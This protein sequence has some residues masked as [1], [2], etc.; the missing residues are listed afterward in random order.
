MPSEE[1]TLFVLAGDA[2]N[3]LNTLAKIMLFFWYF[4]KSNFNSFYFASEIIV[5]NGIF[6]AIGETDLLRAQETL[7]GEVRIALNEMTTLIMALTAAIWKK[8]FGDHMDAEVCLEVADAPNS[9]E[10]SIPFFV[11]VPDG[12][13]S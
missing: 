6:A 1:R 2:A 5:L 4:S 3:Q 13:I 9:F 11:A 7:M 8:N 10:F 12:P